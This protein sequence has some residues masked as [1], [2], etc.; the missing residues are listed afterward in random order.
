[1]KVFR[2]RRDKRN[3]GGQ[4][5]RGRIGGEGQPPG[6]RDL[7]L[8]LLA[9][10]DTPDAGEMTLGSQAINGPS[11]AVGVV[12]QNATLL[13]WMTVWQNVIL[14]L[15]V[16][17]GNR[18]AREDAVREYLS[19]AGLAGFEN[20]YPYELSGGMQQRAAIVRGLDAA[21]FRDGSVRELI[22][23]ASEDLFR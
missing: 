5:F 2:L 22:R 3:C 23:P 13:P 6:A 12:F 4:F 19:I 15:Q 16:G 9:G 14:P 1:M 20:K 21:W 10:L 7:S 11:S 18:A 8:R 17:G